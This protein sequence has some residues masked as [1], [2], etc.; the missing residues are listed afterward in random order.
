MLIIRS[1]SQCL[2][3]CFVTNTTAKKIEEKI[4]CNIYFVKNLGCRFH[5]EGM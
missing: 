5:F 2:V 4:G 3:Q 1:C